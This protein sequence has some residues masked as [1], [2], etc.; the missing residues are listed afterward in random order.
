MP[1]RMAAVCCLLVLLAGGSI[2]AREKPPA[3]LEPIDSLTLANLGRVP[4]LTTAAAC[5]VS[6]NNGMAYYMPDWVIGIEWYKGLMNP[7]TACSNP[8]PFTI[9]AVNM[10]MQFDGATELVVSVDIETVDLTTIAG[11]ATPGE[12][13]TYSIDYTLQVPSTGGGFN[14]W[15]PLDTPITVTGPFF[16]GFYIANE[17]TASANAS[18]FL[19][20]FPVE[21]VTYNAW[22]E[23][24]GWVDLVAG[25]PAFPGRLVMEVAGIPA[26]TSGEP[27]DPGSDTAS[28]SRIAIISPESGSVL[29]GPTEL[30][31]FDSAFSGA[32]EYVSFAFSRGGAFVEFGR[33]YDGACTR[34][35]GTAAAVNGAGYSYLW[36]FSYLPEGA[37]TIRASAV[38]TSGDSSTATVSVVLEPTPPV[39]RITTPIEGNPFCDTVDFRFTCNDEN[40]SYVEL[41][42]KTAQSV[43]SVGLTALGQSAIGD[44]DGNPTDGNAVSAGE[45]GDYCSGPAAAAMAARVW[46]DRG[47]ENIMKQGTGFLTM[48]G[49]G[50]NLATEFDTRRQRGTSDDALLGGLEAYYRDHGNELK[51]SYQRNPSYYDLR[52]CV[53]DAE[54]TAVIGLGGTPGLWL[55]VDGFLGW[56]QSDST[57]RIAVGN[58]LTGGIQVVS[59]RN[60]LGY[61]EISMGTT[62]QPVDIM[63]SMVARNWKV[64]RSL[65]GVDFGANDGWSCRWLADAYA[66]GAVGMFRARAHDV[67]GYV[68]EDIVM[69]E[70]NC[71][72]VYVAGDYDNNRYTDIADL[73]R[74][75]D[76]VVYHQN[77][78]VGGPGRADCNCDQTINIADLI[79]YMNFLF[80]STAAPCR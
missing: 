56:I 67:T 66:D 39:A 27:P 9:E 2:I 52:E 62:W 45:F 48:A 35:N 1:L 30:W 42:R 12:M 40:L 36:D 32:I 18:V 16:A 11:C 22:D 3:R 20:S 74:L 51:F 17:L 44:T 43:Y 78:P 58:P 34:R 6:V 54:Q 5:T 41:Y 79:Y 55:A 19:D 71:A 28:S 50:E 13:L 37:C 25:E 75:I 68:G 46:Y 31:A 8:Y 14:I 10:P 33:D 73:F 26:D 4:S 49:L 77:P 63:I 15:I 38:D 70:H 57:F 72:L 47:Y 69:G 24:T 21:C 23:E 29:M 64:T 80:G 7:A 60:R 61:S 53:E 59:M 76:Y 65:I